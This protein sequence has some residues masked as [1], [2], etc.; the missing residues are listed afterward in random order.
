MTL[1]VL[2]AERKEKERKEDRRVGEKIKRP[3]GGIYSDP[4]IKYPEEMKCHF[5]LM[6]FSPGGEYALKKVTGSTR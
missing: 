4:E 1:W 6:N 3:Q 5:C 2:R